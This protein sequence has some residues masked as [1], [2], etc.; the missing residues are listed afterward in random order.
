[1]SISVC[2]TL[3]GRV[4][5]FKTDYTFPYM[6]LKKSCQIND[7]VMC[8]VTARLRVVSIKLRVISLNVDLIVATNSA[9]CYI[10]GTFNEMYLDY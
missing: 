7:G 1:M 5:A 10:V 4:P 3:C 2:L 8:G 6:A 9:M